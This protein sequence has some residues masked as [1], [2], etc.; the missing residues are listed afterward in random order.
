M[1]NSPP[2]RRGIKNHNTNILGN[3][4]SISKIKK[5][6]RQSR[7]Y[8]AHHEASSDPMGEAVP[9]NNRRD[10]DQGLVFSEE[11]LTSTVI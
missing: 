2:K 8:S 5:T 10:E 9:T 7:L 11:V 1:T 4:N 3:T 6:I